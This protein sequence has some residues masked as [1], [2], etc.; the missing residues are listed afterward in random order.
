MPN[1]DFA[2]ELLLKRALMYLNENYIKHF[3][4]LSMNTSLRSYSDTPE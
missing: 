3:Y 4:W 2:V 1:N